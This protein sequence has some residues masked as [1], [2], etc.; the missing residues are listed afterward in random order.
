M[1]QP[2]P[3]RRADRAGWHANFY[4]RG[5]RYRFRLEG[6]NKEDAQEELQ[7]IHERLTQSSKNADKGQ[8]TI[9]DA[10]VAYWDGKAQFLAAGAPVIRSVILSFMDQLGA[11]MLLS[12]I[13]PKD[14]GG[15]V[16]A[17]RKCFANDTINTHLKQFRAFLN[18]SDKHL[19]AAVPAITWGDYFLPYRETDNALPIETV[20]RIADHAAPHL[21]P[22]ILTALYTGFRKSNVLNLTWEQ[23]DLGAR[24]I[25]VR[26]KS[27]RPGGKLH[28]QPIVLPLHTLLL[29]LGPKESGPVFTYNGGPILNIKRA[30]DTAKRK[31]GIKGPFR[32]HDIRHS[33]ATATMQRSGDIKGVKEMLGH[34]DIKTTERYLHADVGRRRAVLSQTFEDAPN[35]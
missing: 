5:R 33:T 4:I 17:K 13:E 6:V 29:D 28:H 1:K 20:K 27:K 8:Y 2:E 3:Q 21:K 12:E 23:V 16:A 26:V 31:A 32:F 34:A 14:I 7:G 11:D 24:L 22:I 10:A 9:N 25:T 19:G 35:G 15:Y 30:W 18:W